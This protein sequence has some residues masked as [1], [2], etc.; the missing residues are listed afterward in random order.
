M[1]KASKVC[2]RKWVLLLESGSYAR[3]KYRLKR[4]VV[5]WLYSYVVYLLI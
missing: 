5:R 3:S 1:L 4:Y 2:I